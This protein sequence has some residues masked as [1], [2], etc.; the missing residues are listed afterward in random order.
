MLPSNTL[1]TPPL[2][3]AFITQVPPA[4]TPTVDYERG[5]IAIGD[6]SQGLMVQTWKLHMNG[7]D[8][9]VSDTAGNETVVYTTAGVAQ[10]ALAFDQSMNVILAWQTASGCFIR[11]FASGSGYVVKSIPNCLTPRLSLDD[12][13]VEFSSGSDVVLGYINGNSLCVRYQRENY[14][15]EHVLA[16]Y[17]SPRRL[18]AIGM[19]TGNRFQFRM[20]D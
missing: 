13:R 3:A 20:L 18:V 12:N 2:P 4:S 14:D 11:Y 1:T 7:D 16:T 9:V 15:T 10:A 17:T 6:A 8:F 19:N 5:G